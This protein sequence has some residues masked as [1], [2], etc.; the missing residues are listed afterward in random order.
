MNCP[1]DKKPMLVLELE[2]VEIDH[3]TLCG[4]IW[5]DSGELA[6]LLGDRASGERLVSS[7]TPA[8]GEGR[9][10]RCP[11]CGKRM[12]PVLADGVVI[13]RCPRGHGLWFDRDE[14]ASIIKQENINNRVVSFLEDMFREG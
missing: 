8:Q 12:Q 11:V 7:F 10:L 2:G 5:L 1:V 9:K 13:D 3:C 6:L 14:L 4:G